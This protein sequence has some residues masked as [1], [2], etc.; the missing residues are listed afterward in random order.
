MLRVLLLTL[1]L[2]TLAVASEMIL[3]TPGSAVHSY[4]NAINEG[5]M[6]SL[7]QIMVDDS[8]HKDVQIYALSIAFA[9]KEFHQQ[10]K[11]YSTNEDSK[12]IVTLAVEKKLKKRKT[13]E[14]TI[15]KE[16]SLGH[17]RMMVSFKEDSKQKQLYLSYHKEGWKI[18]YLAGRKT[19]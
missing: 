5:D 2:A 9:D 13:R 12:Q 4:Y 8:Y 1:Y 18:D 11:Q 7:K 3:K 14:I 16:L 15:D 17:N 6:H 10:L 19:E